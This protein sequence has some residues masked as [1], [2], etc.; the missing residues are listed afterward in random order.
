MSDTQQ[1]AEA[2]DEGWWRE[3]KLGI[4]DEPTGTGGGSYWIEMAGVLHDQH[5]SDPEA[6]AAIR[7]V[8]LGDL[9]E[10]TI[11]G[12]AAPLFT[13][14]CA[15]RDVQLG[16]DPAKWDHGTQADLDRVGEEDARPILARLSETLSAAPF[17]RDAELNCLLGSAY[18]VIAD[19]LA[20]AKQ[21]LA[22]W[23][24]GDLAGAVRAL[25]TAVADAEAAE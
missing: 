2:V 18:D 3:V 11:G 10:A 5:E 12:G 14:T 6:Q 9:D 25:A 7:S 24:T 20:A 22:S 4:P 16:V 19:L 21:V 8:A 15:G 13:I 23:E 1:A 17:G